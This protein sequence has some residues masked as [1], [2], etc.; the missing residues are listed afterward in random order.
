MARVVVSLT[1]AAIARIY[2]N[3]T[4]PASGD[5]SDESARTHLMRAGD[6]DQYPENLYYPQH[7]AM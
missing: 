2:L 1:Y 4:E 3:N 5:G 7:K 6:C